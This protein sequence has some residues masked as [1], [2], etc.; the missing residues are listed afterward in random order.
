M[1]EGSS[2]ALLTMLSDNGTPE[3]VVI[4][5]FACEVAR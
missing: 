5:N 3:A 1:S 2:L 4:E